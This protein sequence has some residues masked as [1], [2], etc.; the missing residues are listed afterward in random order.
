MTTAC[1]AYYCIQLHY[2]ILCSTRKATTAPETYQ[3][4][5]DKAQFKGG[6]K[7]TAF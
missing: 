1:T 3:T 5:A 2:L 6:E 4:S 7:G